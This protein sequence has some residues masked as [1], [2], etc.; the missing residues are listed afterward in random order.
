MVLHEC[1]G[2]GILELNSI[3]NLKNDVRFYTN[4]LDCKCTYI[5]TI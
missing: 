1:F 5:N 2:L 3:Y 4:Q